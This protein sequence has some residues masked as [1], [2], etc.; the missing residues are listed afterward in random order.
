MEAWNH[1]TW[2][3]SYNTHASIYGERVSGRAKISLNV[4]NMAFFVQ[5]QINIKNPILKQ[6]KI[7]A[8]K[9]TTSK[10]KNL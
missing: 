4:P 5:S 2:T 3:Q 1:T 6:V 9:M 7:K 8:Y 10:H